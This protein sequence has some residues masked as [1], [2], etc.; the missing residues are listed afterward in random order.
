ME[1][2][3]FP[4]VAAIENRVEFLVFPSKIDLI[5][6]IDIQVDSF[7]HVLGWVDLNF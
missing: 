5:K 1:K 2:A 3:L 4:S 7:I 6:K